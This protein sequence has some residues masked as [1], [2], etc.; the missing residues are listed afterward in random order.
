MSYPLYKSDGTLLT[1][2]VDG[3]IDGPNQTATNSGLSFAGPNYVGY[4][5][6]LNE[7]FVKLLENFASGTAP[8]TPNL[9]G[10][11]WFNKT[12][13]TL[14]VFTDLGDGHPKYVPISPVT[15]SGTQPAT[16]R[17]GDIWFNQGTQQTY[18]YDNGSFN[19]IGPQYTRSQGISG[20]IPVVLQD[21][22]ATGVT[23]NVVQIQFGNVVVATV[24]GD[25]TFTPATPVTG[26]GSI[27]P[28]ITFS[29]LVVNPT[30]NSNLVGSVTGNLTGD[31]TGNVV[32]TSL[33][34]TLTGNVV[35]NLTGDVTATTLI[36]NLLGN[37]TSTFGQVVNFGT[38]NAQISGGNI[39]GLTNLTTASVTATNL[40][41]TTLTATNLNSSSAII[42]GGSVI[43]LDNLYADVS[44][45]N[46]F[47]TG[48]AQISGGSIINIA[49]ENATTLQAV[50]FSSPNVAIGGGT[51]ALN[52]LSVG[53]GYTTNFSSGNAQI[54]GGSVTGLSAVQATTMSATILTANSAIFTSGQINNLT[55]SNV[56]LTTANLITSTAT[57]K[58]Y[59]DN[60]AAVATTSMVHSVLPRGIIMMWSGSV[61]TIPPGWALCNG[62]NGTPNLVGQFIV[63]AGISGSNYVPGNTGGNNFVILDGLQLPSHFHT[64]ALTGNTESAGGH[65]HGATSTSTSNATIT[66]PGHN[67]PINVVQG[68]LGGQDSPTR[69]LAGSQNTG[70][71]TTGISVSVA[72]TTNTSLTAAAAHTH[73]LNLSATTS[74]AGQNSAVDIRPPY[75]ALCYIMKTSG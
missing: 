34:G 62:A 64:V 7:N 46:N 37:I 66:D 51:A 30:I 12:N 20:A 41:A 39:T 8:S 13:Q 29:S 32:A 31:V 63:G 71:A 23:H 68:G 10:Q 73:N 49:I 69:A 44:R 48:N 22:F 42:T 2:V 40:S 24:S 27:S 70:T 54:T 65:I 47:S 56:T 16:A 5:L 58:A 50:N 25:P 61:S 74:V 18:L 45:I 6:Y 33:R 14:N 28:G 53:T 38:G 43:G 1:T 67:H 75:Y 60:S 9:Q 4:G 21:G 72:T 3:T 52:A 57:T 11:L 59:N 36:G 26:F 19:L 15:T 55:G 35:G 17:Q